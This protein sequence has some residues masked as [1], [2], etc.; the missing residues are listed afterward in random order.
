MTAVTWPDQITFTVTKEHIKRGQKYMATVCPAA[1]AFRE[2]VEA[3]GLDLPEGWFVS[4][5]YDAA[6][7][8]ESTSTSVAIYG[9]PDERARLGRWQRQFDEIGRNPGPAT[10][11]VTR[12]S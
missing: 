4:T 7:Y 12:Q 5:Y 2:A 3:L 10:F 11:T 9:N 8:F 6:I 1:L